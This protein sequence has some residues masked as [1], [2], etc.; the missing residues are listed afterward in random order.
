MS[1]DSLTSGDGHTLPSSGPVRSALRHLTE[2]TVLAALGSVRTGQ[3]VS[4]NAPLDGPTP[5][6]RPRLRRELRLHNQIRQIPD[7]RYVVL[8]DDII[9]FATQGSSQWDTFAHCGAIEPGVDGVFLGGVGLDETMGQGRPQRLGLS[10][11]GPGIV[12]RGVLLDTVAVL[13]PGGGFLS[14]EDR[15]DRTAVE[16]CL[17]RQDAELRPGDAVFIYTGFGKRYDYLDEKMPT[18]AGGIDVSTMSLWADAKVSAL[19]SDNLAVESSPADFRV[20]IA[21]LRD[22]GILLGELWA[23]EE[24]ARLTRSL[25]RYD[26][27]LVSVPLNLPYAFGSPANALAIL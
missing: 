17:K 13:R 15:V 20:H 25:K 10:A 8:N 21:A 6:T 19:I 26:F 22:L 27:L 4:L 18:R 11:L 16:A 9:E 3:V 23:L 12:T 24:L 7:G 5:T 1:S 2:A 14:E